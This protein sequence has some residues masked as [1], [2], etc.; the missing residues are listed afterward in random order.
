MDLVKSVL[1]KV[2]RKILIKENITKLGKIVEDEDKFVCFVNKHKLELSNKINKNEYMK[3]FVLRS[4]WIGDEEG[5]RMM[6]RCELDKPVYYIFDGIEF[7]K[8]IE[9]HGLPNTFIV[10][11]NCIF[12]ENIYLFYADNVIFENNKYYNRGSL[13]KKAHTFIESR[14]KVNNL[15]FINDN[16]KNFDVDH[17][18]SFFGMDVK[19][20][21]LEIIDTKIEI[22]NNITY[23]GRE[24]FPNRGGIN[25]KA[26]NVTINN[27]SIDVAE[28]YI[29][30]DDVNIDSKSSIKASGG[31]LI[32][33]KSGDIEC[34]NV[35]S[36]YFVYNGVEYINRDN[37]NVCLE[38]VEL[39][40][41]RQQLVRTMGNILKVCVNTNEKE[42]DEIRS[43][44]N[45][46]SLRRVLK[47][48]K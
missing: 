47:R 34:F 38:K 44:L 14:M 41:E 5:R 24:M 27:S 33:D 35:D 32:E 13:Y 28:V 42:I 31:I 9:V 43:S 19:V 29:D 3:E 11:K 25:V 48:E 7:N 37:V 8:A 1:K 21:N 12:K 23:L 17:H 18:P 46:K 36:P 39:Q 6:R 10:F 26:D 45:S 30:S 22:I 16:F 2:L 20:G 15:K 40:R 4:F